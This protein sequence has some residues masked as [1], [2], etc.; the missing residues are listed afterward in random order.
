MSAH[1]YII[2]ICSFAHK[3]GEALIFENNKS[4]KRKEFKSKAETAL[5]FVESYGLVIMFAIWYI[6]GSENYSFNLLQNVHYMYEFHF[7][8]IGNV[9]VSILR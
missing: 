3:E 9:F 8:E 2:N 7:T 1:Q 6:H 4:R 5:W